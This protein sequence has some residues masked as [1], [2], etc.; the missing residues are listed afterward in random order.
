MDE[1][2]EFV[3]FVPPYCTSPKCFN[4]LKEN[5]GS[6]PPQWWIRSGFYKL[7]NDVKVQR[8][9]CSLCHRRFSARAFKSYFRFKIPDRTLSAR[10]LNIFIVGASNRDMGRFF[11]VS[12]G[13]IRNR[14]NRMADQAILIHYEKLKNLKGIWE[15][16]AYDGLENFAGSQYEPNYINQAIGAETFFTYDCNFSPMNRKGRMSERQKLRNL[17]LSK[18][19]GI[20]PK[21]AIRLAT[22]VLLKRLLDKQKSGLRLELLSDEHFQ[23]RRSIKQDLKGALL[24]HKTISAKATRNF[25]NILFPVNHADLIIRKNVA[26][27]SR[28]TIS[29][30]KTHAAMCKKY[31]LFMSYKNYMAP[32]FTKKLIRRPRAHIESPAQVVG[33]ETKI[34]SFQEFFC[35]TRTERQIQIPPEWKMIKKGK[36]PYARQSPG[37]QKLDPTHT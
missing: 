35:E 6:S 10:I 4:H 1:K 32:Q 13:C 33:L 20:F 8:F 7:H 9:S 31:F 24:D 3:S 2:F 23:Y 18:S 37:S 29:F 28:E 15:P 5:L 25:Q 17:E 21:N 34:L 27:F 16:V 26:A 19:S 14:L 12:E 30:S 11:G 22:T 36:T